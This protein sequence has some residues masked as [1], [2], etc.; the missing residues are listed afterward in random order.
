MRAGLI[1]TSLIWGAGVCRA[2]TLSD[3][4]V[5]GWNVRVGTQTFAGLYQFTTNTLLVETAQAIA[6]MGSD[7]IKGYLGPDFPRQYHITLP[8][9][10]TNLLTLARDRTLVPAGVGHA[11]PPFRLLGLSVF[12]S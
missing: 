1:W 5:E 11:L 4:A 12:Q 7:V 2:G 3:P 9:N 6:G 8:G 10:V